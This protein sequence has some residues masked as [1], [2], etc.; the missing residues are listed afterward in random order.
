[1]GVPVWPSAP[2]RRDVRN[3]SS[4]HRRTPNRGAAQLLDPT[5]LPAVLIADLPDIE[6][7]AGIALAVAAGGAI[8]IAKA[9]R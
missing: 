1:M 3:G 7:M 5:G 6:S 2:G 9:P 4:E 8:K